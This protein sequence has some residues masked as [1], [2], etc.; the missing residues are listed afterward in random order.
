[1]RS[2]VMSFLTCV[3]IADMLS[4]QDCHGDMVLH[5]YHD[6]KNRINEFSRGTLSYVTK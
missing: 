3:S 1:M 2:T 4:K 5:R 6:Y